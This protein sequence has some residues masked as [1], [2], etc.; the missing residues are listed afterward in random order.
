MQY[1]WQDPDGN[2]AITA[3]S[4]PTN[5]A[6]M[7]AALVEDCEL[8]AP[9][10]SGLRISDKDK[11]KLTKEEKDSLKILKKEYRGNLHTVLKKVPEFNPNSQVVN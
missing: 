5:I 7:E 1:Y 9:V 3:T 6:I 10:D 8:E 11:A 2:Y 4:N